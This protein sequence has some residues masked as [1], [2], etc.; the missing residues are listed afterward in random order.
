MH[1]R[2]SEK[3]A[4]EKKEK[5]PSSAG[6]GKKPSSFLKG[7][8]RQWKVDVDVEATTLAGAIE[9]ATE[10]YKAYEKELMDLLDRHPKVSL[11]HGGM[12]KNGYVL[13]NDTIV[14]K[15]AVLTHAPDGGEGAGTPLKE[16]EFLVLESSCDVEDL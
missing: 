14:G 3:L 4:E 9:D 7:F 11:L 13:E 5:T 1:E 8:G 10:A 16:G 6:R 12:R 2:P 15:G